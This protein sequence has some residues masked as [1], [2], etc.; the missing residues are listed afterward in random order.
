MIVTNIVKMNNLVIEVNTDLSNE[1]NSN[2]TKRT[3]I[4]SKESLRQFASPAG[5]VDFERNRMVLKNSSLISQILQA[6]N[7]ENIAV[8]L[9]LGIFRK[10]HCF[11]LL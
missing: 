5:L 2:E 11:E 8:L 1:R 7:S 6:E 10:M 4:S 9:R 3:V